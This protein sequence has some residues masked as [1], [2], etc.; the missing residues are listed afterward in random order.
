MEISRIIDKLIKNFYKK[1]FPAYD[2][3]KRK[4][5]KLPESSHYASLFN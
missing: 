1:K 3:D 2:Y 5:L 4:F